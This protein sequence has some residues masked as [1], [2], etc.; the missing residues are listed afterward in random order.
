MIQGLLGPLTFLN[1]WVLAGLAFLPVLWFLLR[2]TPPAPKRMTFPPARFLAGL[3]PDEHAT[4]RTPWWIL[5]MRLLAAALIIIALAH[6][7]LNRSAALPG[8]ADVRIVIDNGWAAAQNWQ[9][10]RDS[11]A[12]LVERAGRER[13]ALHIMTTAPEPGSAS[14]QMHG[15]LSQ[16]Q[17]EAVIR[18]LTPHPWPSDYEAAI[19]MLEDRSDRSG[20]HSFFL[21][22]GLSDGPQADMLMRRLQ[23][24]GGLSI[25]TPEASRLPLLLRPAR[26]PGQSVEFLIDGPPG[27]TESVPVRVQAVAHDG[28]VIDTI[29]PRLQPR[30]FPQRIRMDVPE[31]LRGD[32]ARL[33]ISGRDSAGSVLLMDDRFRRRNIGIAAPAADQTPLIEASYYLNRALE[34]YADIQMASVQAL[35]GANPSV[36]ILP[37]VG[38]MPT[39]DMNA[40]ESWVR[41]GGLLLR[42]AGPNMSQGEEFLTPVP[43]RRGGRSLDGSLTWDEPV[44]LAAFPEHSPYYGL[45]V[46]QDLTIRRQLLADPV[47]GLDRRSWAVLED[48]TPLI[49]ANRVDN[50]LIV[51]VHTTATPEWSELPLS[52]LFVQ[53][54]RRTINLA[55][56]GGTIEGAGG[57]HLQPLTVLDGFGR[58]A[59]PAPSV[60]PLPAS[61]AMNFIP[62][63]SHPPGIYSQAGYSHILNLG[64]HLPRLQRFESFPMGADG[65]RYGHRI[66]RD[67][68]PLLLA[69][70]L[71]LFLMDWLVMI[72]LQAG[73]R[74]HRRRS[75]QTAAFVLALLA[76]PAFNSQAQASPLEYAGTLHLAYVQSGDP[77]VDATT[78]RGLE[79]L[80]DV[81]NR[82]TSV[83]PAGVVAVNPER[84]E[85]SFFPLLYWAISPQ[86]QPLSADAVRRVQNY[87]D[88]GGTILFDTRDGAANQRPIRTQDSHG[89]I[90]RQIAGGLNIQ[91]LV[92]MPSEHVLIQTFYL[93]RNTPGRYESGTLWIEET[94]ADGRDGVS[95][96]IIGSQDWA[97]AWAAVGRNERQG[98]YGANRQEEMSLRFGVNLV[99]YALTGNY[100]ADQ[101]HLPHILERLGQ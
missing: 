3:I 61:E 9:L 35:I 6:P 46:P 76:I 19:R 49:T 28:R 4:S 77:A 34:P 43:L 1:P 68:M 30:E 25:L 52:G 45:P 22:H 37:D 70:A 72:A 90:L 93:M 51:L 95:S 2:V 10:I 8:R 75:V 89:H 96:V 15:P 14:P 23:H 39:A 12:D 44:R 21:S 88:H 73:W 20:K 71:V 27:L 92:P 79:T 31:T 66:E 32:I 59:Q 81:L 18:G 50:G 48:G 57:T 17:A 62:D 100:K 16:G 101:V 33:R 67:L 55:G 29:E 47:E 11:A 42:F 86:T 82:R 85:L 53:I 91:P 56:G 65:A 74:F 99:M 54:L 80:V 41:E 7:I 40:L 64:D 58:T 69:G 60:Q 83:E 87:L 63:S 24:Q 94:S 36:I 26:N 5:L 13:R 98:L 97:A 38:A 78:R 84:D